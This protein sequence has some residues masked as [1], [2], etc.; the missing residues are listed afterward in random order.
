MRCNVSDGRNLSL[1]HRLSRVGPPTAG[2]PPCRGRD[3]AR[4]GDRCVGCHQVVRPEQ[5]HKC[6]PLR[7]VC[8][9]LLPKRH[10]STYH[11]STGGKCIEWFTSSS[12]V[13]RASESDCPVH[14]V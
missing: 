8:E 12:V 6:P 9:P 4:S 2:I 1:V 3:L 11:M 13:E 7:A 10:G 14:D 5:S